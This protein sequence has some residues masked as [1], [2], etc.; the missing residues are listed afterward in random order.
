MTTILLNVYSYTHVLKSHATLIWMYEATE[1]WFDS[2]RGGQPCSII[3][4]IIII[5]M[6][7][8]II[9]II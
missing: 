4:M 8:I 3:M 5:I 9:I 1:I 6:M 7:L 2:Q